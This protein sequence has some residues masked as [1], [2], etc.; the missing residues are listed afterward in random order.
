MNLLEI[1]SVGTPA[2]SRNPVIS[3]MLRLNSIR[4][5]MR[6]CLTPLWT[7][8]SRVKGLLTQRKLSSRHLDTGA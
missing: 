2:E 8:L 3:L 1:L 5:K 7:G 6:C 4:A